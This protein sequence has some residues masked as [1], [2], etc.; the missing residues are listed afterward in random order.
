MHYRV[1]EYPFSTKENSVRYVV[2]CDEQELIFYQSSLSKRWWL[3]V[4][5]E[6]DSNLESMLISCSEEDFYTAEK[7]T[8]PER[9]WKA[10][11]RSII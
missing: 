4:Q 11:R 2:S 8:V 7:G 6:Y 5:P 3:E 9:W 1:N 10:I